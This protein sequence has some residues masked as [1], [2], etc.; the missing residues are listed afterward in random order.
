M[1]TDGEYIRQVAKQTDKQHTGQ[2]TSKNIEEFFKAHEPEV[3][4]WSKKTHLRTMTLLQWY[5]K[6]PPVIFSI[7]L[8]TQSL[9]MLKNPGV[10]K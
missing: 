9:K 10:E 8:G 5:K 1:E 4:V 2:S 6:K 7:L 3:L